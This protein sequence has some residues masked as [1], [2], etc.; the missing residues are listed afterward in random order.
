M[1]NPSKHVGNK[2][3]SPRHSQP[4]TL[5]IWRSHLPSSSKFTEPWLRADWLIFYVALKHW[6][7]TLVLHTAQKWATFIW[8]LKDGSNAP[9]QCQRRC[10]KMWLMSRFSVFPVLEQISVVCGEFTSGVSP[11][12]G[13]H[14]W[15]DE[16][17]RDWCLSP[18]SCHYLLR[19]TS[20]WSQHQP[21][22]LCL[23]PIILN[24]E[25]FLFLSFQADTHFS[26][27][28]LFLKFSFKPSYPS[29]IWQHRISNSKNS[30][31]LHKFDFKMT[32][33]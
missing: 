20:H 33:L 26:P 22:I 23:K 24:L 27:L 7:F 3:M 25:P 30:F 11:R 13:K 8:Q 12:K 2:K 5:T 4:H 6:L 29:I 19:F 16:R 28:I 31:L 10:K 14:Q 21:Q 1:C 9:T 17:L 18:L 32:K 15:M